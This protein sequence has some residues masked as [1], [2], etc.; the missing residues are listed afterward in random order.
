[1]IAYVPR[2]LKEGSRSR[3][4]P[5]RPAELPGV[6]RRFKKP[7]SSSPAPRRITALLRRGVFPAES[8]LLTESISLVG[9]TALPGG[10]SLKPA[11]PVLVGHGSSEESGQ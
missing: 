3:A 1:V 11:R 6:A 8:T 5:P 7:A 2:T 4:T 10:W 9:I